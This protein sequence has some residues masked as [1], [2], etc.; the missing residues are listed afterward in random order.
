MQQQKSFRILYYLNN[1]AITFLLFIIVILTIGIVMLAFNKPGVRVQDSSTLNLEIIRT[2]FGCIAAT[3]GLY[4]F[5]LGLHTIK[6]DSFVQA[7]WSRKC[8]MASLYFFAASILVA[9]EIS[10]K[11]DDFFLTFLMYNED[12]IGITNSGVLYLTI[13][14]FLSFLSNFQPKPSDV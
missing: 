7:Y 11:K 3:I 2:Y 1:V 6:I 9:I 4:Q 12:A 10:T 8:I 14:L 5:F 13:A